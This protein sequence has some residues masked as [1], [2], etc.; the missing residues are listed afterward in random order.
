MT[1]AQ[2]P[3][4]EVQALRDTIATLRQRIAD[5]ES[6]RILG[7][8]D[9][10]ILRAMEGREMTVVQISEA[11]R[12]NHKYV[13]ARLCLPA[14]M[15]RAERCGTAKRHGGGSGQNPVLWRAKA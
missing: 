12:M 5:L 3:I 7:A 8:A 11:T 6:A 4:A 13:R 9:R 15:S 1:T 2:Y 14:L 10:V